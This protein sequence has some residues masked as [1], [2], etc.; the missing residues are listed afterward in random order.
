MC[1]NLFNYVLDN[2]NFIYR[3]ELCSN[4]D[5]NVN[6]CITTNEMNRNTHDYHLNKNMIYDVSLPRTWEMRC[7]NCQKNTEIIIFQY[8][9]DALNVGYMCTEC[10]HYWKN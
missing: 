8:N 5:T 4:E 3:C 2:N 9:P 10:E 6:T 7:P 1:G